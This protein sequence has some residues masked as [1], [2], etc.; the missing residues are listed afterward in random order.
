MKNKPLVS[1]VIPT[2]NS[3]KTLAK[4]LEGIKNQSYKNIEVIIVDG[5]STDTTIQIAKNYEIKIIQR[6]CNKPEARNIGIVNA[7]GIFILFLDSDMSLQSKVVEEAVWNFQ[8]EGNNALFIDEE[9]ENVGFWRKCRNLEKTIYRGNTIIEAPRFYERNIFKSI[10]F[11]EKNE[12]PDEYDFYYSARQFGMKEGRINSKVIIFESPFNFRKKFRHGK[13]FFYFKFK[14][15]KEETILKQINLCYRVKLLLKSFKS[16]SIYGLGLVFIKFLEYIF[17]ETGLFTSYFDRKILRL[18]FSIRGHFDNQAAETY[19]REM[20]EKSA[21]SKFVDTKER[22][23]I[24]NLLQEIKFKNN[25]KVL[26]VGAGNGRFSREFLRLGF[27]VTALD[28]SPNM[29]KY[30]KNNIRN[31]KVINEDISG[32][33]LNLNQRGD[34]FNLIFSFRTLKYVRDRKRALYNIKKLLKKNGYAIIE[35]PNLLNPF[36]FPPY[37][38]APLLLHFS[39]RESIKYLIFSNFITKNSFIKELEGAGVKI[40]KVEKLFF[41]PHSIYSKIENK[42][43]LKIICS[44]GNTLSRFSPRSL[45]FVVRK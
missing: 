21:G 24:L 20:F 27:D 3:E 19:E 34:R 39:N 15:I 18:P 11:D 13:F 40:I 14:H 25:A 44:I 42:K 1:I 35:M 38:L 29:C 16:S 17:F 36:Y 23:T 12:G 6:P 45:I 33:N 2:Y 10:L 30:L 7:K 31:L 5:L 28:I 9:Y 4:C 32:W 43:F 8:K 22:E 26:D 37:K 41:F